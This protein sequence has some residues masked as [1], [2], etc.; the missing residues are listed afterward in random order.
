MQHK[1][2]AGQTTYC[3][4]QSLCLQTAERKIK[5]TFHFNWIT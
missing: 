3:I 2:T 5:G 4:S 1:E